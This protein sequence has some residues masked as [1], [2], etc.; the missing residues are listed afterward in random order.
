MPVDLQEQDE[1]SAEIDNLMKMHQ[2]DKPS[3]MV[4]LH[5]YI[6][7]ILK[8]KRVKARAN[9]LGWYRPHI[10]ITTV[11]TIDGR[12]MILP[13][14]KEVVVRYLLNG[15]VYG[16]QTRL[17]KKA[18]DPVPMWLLDYPSVTEVK[19][20][21]ESPRIQ[22]FLLLKDTASAGNYVVDLSS[23][24]AQVLVTTP[25][26]LGDEIPLNFMLPNGEQIDN[27]RAKVVRVNHS[28]EEYSVGVSF[29]PDD[30][31][32]MKKI[33]DYIE[34]CDKCVRKI[35]TEFEVPKM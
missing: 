31:E 35:L 7:V 18:Q 28:V 16:F 6:E 22:T 14:G 8:N 30:R 21:R 10:L 17:N 9:L 3:F 23:K 1:S 27:L 29:H 2:P 32:P 24:G 34:E 5:L 20:L 33:S 15:A 13:L 19:N 26:G 25:K 12:M 11:P 4:G